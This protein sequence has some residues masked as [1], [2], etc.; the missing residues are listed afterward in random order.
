MFFVSLPGW[1]LAVIL[2]M[3]LSALFQQRGHAGA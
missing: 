3:A 1:F 2:Y